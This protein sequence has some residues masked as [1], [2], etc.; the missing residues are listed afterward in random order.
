MGTEASLGAVGGVDSECEV[1]G[2]GIC[3]EGLDG[4]EGLDDFPV[5]CIEDAG[6]EGS[7]G[8][9]FLRNFLF[10]FVT[11]LDPSILTV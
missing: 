9:I 10:L 5:G 1:V 11:V 3:M 2:C 4:I 8:T 7:K 6:W